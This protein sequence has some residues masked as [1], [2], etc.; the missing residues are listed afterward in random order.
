MRIQKYLSERGILSRRAAEKELAAGNILVN[1]KP[2]GLG[3]QI[4]PENDRLS[5][6]GREI[7]PEKKERVY[8][9][10]HKPVGVVTT[11]SD[12]KGRKSVTELTENVGTRVWPVGR[13]DM[14]SEGLLLLTNDGELTNGLTH[15]GHEVKK[16]YHV[17]VRGSV[18]RETLRQ[19]SSPMTMDDGYVIRP[20]PVTVLFEKE[21]ETVLR[22][23]LSEGRNRQIR[24]MCRQVGLKIL[25]LCRVAVGEVKLGS[26]PPGKWRFLTRKEVDSLK[27]VGSVDENTKTEA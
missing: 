24:Q 15:P 10:L 20:V 2:A 22:M 8:L 18:S 23:E 11:L 1:G 17:A 19:L 27:A 21:G 7:E 26:L 6:R 3:D 13:L 9:M 12:E 25:R 5:L 16:I 4:D 14:Y